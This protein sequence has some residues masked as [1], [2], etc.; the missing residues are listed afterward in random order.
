[1]L[2]GLGALHDAK[3]VTESH[4]AET[5][6]HFEAIHAANEVTDNT[7]QS[8]G[9]MKPIKAL[10]NFAKQARPQMPAAQP[11]VVYETQTMPGV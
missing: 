1:M 7:Q 2:N 8:G 10:V 6:K 5:R 4:M 9:L 11:T 3:I